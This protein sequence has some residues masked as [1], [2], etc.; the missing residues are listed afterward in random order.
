MEPEARERE[1]V[2]IVG[3]ALHVVRVPGA[4]QNRTSVLVEEYPVGD[5]GGPTGRGNIEEEQGTGVKEM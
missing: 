3:V 5:D 4:L 1:Y 2:A